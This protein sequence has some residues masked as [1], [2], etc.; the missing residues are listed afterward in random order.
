MAKAAKG[1]NSLLSE[2]DCNT[3]NDILITG[4][5]NLLEVIPKY[6]FNGTV[7]EDQVGHVY[8]NPILGPIFSN[9]D[10]RRHLQW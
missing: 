3:A 8:A 2:D 9:P 6:K 7:N 4:I 10:K 1:M 5:R